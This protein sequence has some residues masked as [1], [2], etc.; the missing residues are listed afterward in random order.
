MCTSGSESSEYGT[1]KTVKAKFRPWLQVKVLENLC[2]VPS[3][4]GIVNDS[5]VLQVSSAPIHPGV[6]LRENLESIS[7]RCHLFE[8]AFAWELTQNQIP[9]ICPCFASWAEDSQDWIL[10][11]A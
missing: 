9:S 1:C 2:V 6:E 5:A 10:A 4:R 7:D 8:V 11:L 3:V